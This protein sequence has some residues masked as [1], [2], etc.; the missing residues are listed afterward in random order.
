M[1]EIT[2][3]LNN[4]FVIP[5]Y[6]VNKECKIIVLFM[7]FIKCSVIVNNKLKHRQKSSFCFDRMESEKADIILMRL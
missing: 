1:D 7:C 2:E 6:V 3:E 5:V 4:S